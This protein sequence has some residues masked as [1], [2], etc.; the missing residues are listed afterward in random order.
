MITGDIT[1]VTVNYFARGFREGI[2]DASGSPAI[3]K[4]AFNLI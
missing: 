2:P 1:G 3:I 4:A